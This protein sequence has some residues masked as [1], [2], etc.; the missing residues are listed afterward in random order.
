MFKIKNILWMG[1]LALACASCSDD[2]LTTPPSD[3]ISSET[4]YKSATQSEQ[5]IIGL[6]AD[7]STLDLNGYIY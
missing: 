2:Y 1:V 7:M 6:Y 3:L 5:A 4:F